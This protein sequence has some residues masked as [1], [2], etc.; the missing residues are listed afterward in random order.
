MRSVRLDEALETKLVEAASV[1]GKPVSDII[2][3]AI[4][5]RCEAILGRRL[6]HRLNDVTGI[7]HSRGGRARRSGEAF[8]AGLVRKRD[9]R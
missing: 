9:N 6:V 4:E 2:R 7:V 5:E 8:T 3:Q 1:S